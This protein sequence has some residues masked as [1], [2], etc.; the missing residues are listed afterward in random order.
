MRR[1]LVLKCRDVISHNLWVVPFSRDSDSEA[2]RYE[3][4]G[5]REEQRSALIKRREEPTDNVAEEGRRTPDLV[6]KFVPSYH[7]RA[8]TTEPC[9]RPAV[10]DSEVGWST[11]RGEMLCEP[12]DVTLGSVAPK[13][14]SGAMWFGS[15]LWF[16][17]ES[18]STNTVP[19]SP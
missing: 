6:A 12:Q 1:S 7:P 14:N 15:S 9:K 5:F 17:F 19:S 10:E 3:I 18:Q 13:K 11:E 4:G 8:A 16:R 2:D